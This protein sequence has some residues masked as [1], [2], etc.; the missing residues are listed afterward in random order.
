MHKKSVV[1]LSEEERMLYWRAH[2][3]L[4]SLM[5][6]TAQI[7]RLVAQRTTELSRDAYRPRERDRRT[8]A[9]RER[10]CAQVR[11]ATAH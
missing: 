10:R 6:R 7:E 11:N 3:Q 5:S 4:L 1:R 9:G 8:G 2:G